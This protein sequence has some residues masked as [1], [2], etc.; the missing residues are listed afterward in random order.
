MVVDVFLNMMVLFVQFL[1]LWK[2][3]FAIPDVPRKKIPGGYV[4]LFLATLGPS[5]VIFLAIYSQ[6]VEEGFNSLWLA[7]AFIILGSL[8]YV[9]IRKFVKPGIPDVDPFRLDP[10][11]VSI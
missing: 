1:A 11:E 6:L 4:G 9:P 3:R 2:L 10:E 7:L 8:L 5:I